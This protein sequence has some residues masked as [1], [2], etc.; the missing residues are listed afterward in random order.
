MS[1]PTLTSGALPT[2]RRG[3]IHFK[4]TDDPSPAEGNSAKL[5]PSRVDK[6]ES[7][8]YR[9]MYSL[10]T[11]SW[12]IE[13]CVGIAIEQLLRPRFAEI[14][15]LGRALSI[16]KVHKEPR[17]CELFFMPL[18]EV[19]KTYS[20]R[21]PKCVEWV[22]LYDPDVEFVFW[23]ELFQP[24]LGGGR[25]SLLTD[26]LCGGS[27]S[28]VTLVRGENAQPGLLDE[29]DE[30]LTKHLA[31][32][33]ASREEVAVQLATKQARLEKNRKKK[34]KAKAKK[35]DEKAA[36]AAVAEEEREEQVRKEAEEIA[37]AR[38]ARMPAP[39]LQGADFASMFKKTT[40]AAAVAP[41]AAAVP[42]V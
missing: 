25:Q 33:L 21:F 20:A 2:Q 40:T 7:K 8:T 41:D 29:G 26:E 31:Q 11:D 30:R 24:R 4:Y 35:A 1:K 32:A 23:A 10:P 17:V 42:L 16:F 5:E 12:E 38:A 13:N 28:R 22:H 19:I 34:E 36:E 14:K 9:E 3:A 18:D 27:G 37:A 6:V 15:Q 39:G